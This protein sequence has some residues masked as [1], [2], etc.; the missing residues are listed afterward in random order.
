[1]SEHKFRNFNGVC[2]EGLHKDRGGISCGR[3]ENDPIHG[4]DL[5]GLTVALGLPMSQQSAVLAWSGESMGHRWTSTE[6]EELREIWNPTTPAEQRTGISDRT[7][8]ALHDVNMLRAG[9]QFNDDEL[10]ML[11]RIE[12]ALRERGR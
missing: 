2:I 11:S 8:A 7:A 4:V 12:Q 10:A 5:F 9:R 3:P 1:M 6:V